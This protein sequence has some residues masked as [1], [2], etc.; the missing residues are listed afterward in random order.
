MSVSIFSLVRPP[1]EQYLYL[2]Y[3]FD[4]HGAVD[5]YVWPD[6]EEEEMK[7]QNGFAGLLILHY[8]ATDHDRAVK[9]IEELSGLIISTRRLLGLETPVKEAQKL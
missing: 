1:Y 6:Q 8:P 5:V 2:S 3:G 7:P 9:E 4:R